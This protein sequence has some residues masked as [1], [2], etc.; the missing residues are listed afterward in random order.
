[1]HKHQDHKKIFTPK[2]LSHIY[3]CV[4]NKMPKMV[5]DFPKPK[6]VIYVTQIHEFYDV[7][8]L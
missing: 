4:D 5:C 7:E 2:L 6:A 8:K 1:M 3:T